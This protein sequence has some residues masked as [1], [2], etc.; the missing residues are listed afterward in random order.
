VRSVA[1]R[2]G[3][4]VPSLYHN[5]ATYSRLLQLIRQ[6]V[7]C[8]NGKDRWLWWTHIA[9]VNPLEAGR[10][11]VLVGCAGSADRR[12]CRSSAGHV[13]ITDRVR[14][15]RVSRGLTEHPRDG[16][17]M[18]PIADGVARSDDQEVDRR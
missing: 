2:S 5:D 9:P 4:V 8:F 1:Q 3:N 18:M 17:A 15:E 16:Q 14:H 12:A 11:V 6:R 7:L 10:I 13:A